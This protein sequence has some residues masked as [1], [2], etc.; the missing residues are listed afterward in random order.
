MPQRPEKPKSW[1]NPRNIRDDD[2]APPTFYYDSNTSNSSKANQPKQRLTKGK[3]GEIISKNKSQSESSK[4][5]QDIPVTSQQEPPPTKFSSFSIQKGTAPV[6]QSCVL[7]KQLVSGSSDSETV[8]MHKPPLDGDSSDV[9]DIPLPGE[10]S[11]TK[12][13]D[14]MLKS[15]RNQT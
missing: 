7:D 5:S 12:S 3:F 10:D 2:F 14:L 6:N 4:K 8:A 1:V 15:L 11:A 13:I 9:G